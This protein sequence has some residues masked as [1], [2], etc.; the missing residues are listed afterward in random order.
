MLKNKVGLVFGYFIVFFNFY[1]VLNTK[2]LAS[3]SILSFVNN[4]ANVIVKQF[5]KLAC[6]RLVLLVKQ[7]KF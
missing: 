1:S 6:F 3:G 5:C 2:S 7:I 4:G